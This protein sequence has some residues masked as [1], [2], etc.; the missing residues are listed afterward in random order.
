[1]QKSAYD[2]LLRKSLGLTFAATFLVALLLRLVLVALTPSSNSFVDIGI[3]VDSGQIVAAGINPYDFN[4]NKALREQLRLDEFAFNPYTC[5]TQQRWDYYANGNLPLTLLFLGA[6]EYLFPYN[7]WAYRIAF[8]IV[9]SL[10]SA[11]ICL[12]VL[13]Y[14]KTE[15]GNPNFL[16]ILSLGVFSPW[17]LFDGTIIPEDK[18]LQTLLMMLALYFSFGGPTKRNY[19]LTILFLGASIAFKAIGVFLVPI[20]FLALEKTKPVSFSELV[21][22]Q[23]LF[24]LVTFTLLVGLSSFIYFAPFIPEVFLMATG[25]LATENS[26][27]PMHASIWKLIAPFIPSAFAVIRIGGLASMLG[28]LLYGIYRNAYGAVLV[29]SALMVLFINYWLLSGSMN[30]MNM[31]ITASL[32]ALGAYYKI[33]GLIYYYAFG[34]ATAVTLI[35][36]LDT[37]A[38]DVDWSVC[39]ALFVLVFLIFFLVFT[40]RA[41][42]NDRENLLA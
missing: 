34:S 42:Q 4:D 16:A 37:F 23:S 33:R 22:K 38:P 17:L 27:V 7:I 13:R 3:Y 32:L 29:F 12:F 8:A 36:F 2:L 26:T 31:S 20:C 19:W 24:R 6:I 28:L 1:M 40:F 15:T 11:T 18:G 10:L 14:W 5:E 35:V 21:G 41:L 39:S 30:R 25:R 9:D